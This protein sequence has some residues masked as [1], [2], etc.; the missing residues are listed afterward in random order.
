MYLG[1]LFWYLTLLYKCNAASPKTY[2]NTGIFSF[3]FILK[4]F[5]IVFPM[6]TTP[7]PWT[8]ADKIHNRPYIGCRLLVACSRGYLISPAHLWHVKACP[9]IHFKSQVQTLFLVVVSSE[10]Q[11]STES[12]QTVQQLRAASSVT[13]TGADHSLQHANQWSPV[14]SHFKGRTYQFSHKLWH[15]LHHL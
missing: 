15:W 6:S 11:S 2:K 13:L 9:E 3:Y 1:Y 4:T 5:G 10:L 12:S 14:S 8:K 7:T